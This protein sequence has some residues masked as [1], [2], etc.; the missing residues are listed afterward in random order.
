M[1]SELLWKSPRVV[2][3]IAY[4]DVPKA[5]EWLT[6]AFGFRERAEARL[7]GNGFCLAWM[8]VGDG[9]INLGTS[10]GHE[11]RSPHADGRINQSLKVYVEDVD[12]HCAHARAAGAA[13][14]EE[15]QDRFWGGRM[16]RA[17]DH[18]GH[19]WEFSQIDRELD[20]TLWKLPPGIKRGAG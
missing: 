17:R 13:I 16:Y 15:P 3:S 14:I 10:G 4:D 6:H 1:P 18:E 12:A 11:T 20:A 7:T 9:L 8:E 2:P 5:V 19:A